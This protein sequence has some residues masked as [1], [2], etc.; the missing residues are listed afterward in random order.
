MPLCVQ[1]NGRLGQAWGFLIGKRAF[2][3]FLLKVESLAEMLTE[4]D[5]TFAV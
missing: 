2:Y 4:S 1:G 3:S 5:A